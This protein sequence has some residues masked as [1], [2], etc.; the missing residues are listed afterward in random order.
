MF[1]VQKATSVEF[2]TLSRIFDT[3]LMHDFFYLFSVRCCWF[4]RDSKHT[5]ELWV[6][7]MKCNVALFWSILAT[8]VKTEFVLVTYM[9]H[10]IHVPVIF[11]LHWISCHIKCV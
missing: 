7:A 6:S 4:R 3:L 11:F 8:M 1:F 5:A 10:T 2:Y 9:W